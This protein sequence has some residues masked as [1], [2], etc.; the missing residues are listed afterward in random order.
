MNFRRPPQRSERHRRFVAGHLCVACVRGQLVRTERPSS[1]AAHVNGLGEH[2]MGMKAGDIFTAPLCFDHHDEH[3]GRR[4]G[5]QGPAFWRH[6]GIDPKLVVLRLGRA[7]P[8]P[9][10]R[11]AAAEFAEVA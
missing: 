3:D 4:K 11:R 8:A 5:C 9:E 1:Q 7:S 2:G 6:Y 10:I